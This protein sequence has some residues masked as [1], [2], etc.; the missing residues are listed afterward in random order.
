MRSILPGLEW[1]KSAPSFRYKKRGYW[2]ADRSNGCPLKLQRLKINATDHSVQE[3]RKTKRKVDTKESR[4]EELQVKLKLI[5]MKTT[6]KDII[7]KTKSFFFEEISKINK[8]RVSWIEQ[9]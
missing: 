1:G 7:N 6:A 9:K 3:A 8:P 4:G 5:I 2:E